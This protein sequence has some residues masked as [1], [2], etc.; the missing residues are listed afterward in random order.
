M[1]DHNLPDVGVATAQTT[2]AAAEPS[3]VPAARVNSGCF[4]RGKD[5]RRRSQKPRLASSTNARA[6]AHSR[7]TGQLCKAAVDGSIRGQGAFV[8][9]SFSQ[10]GN[11]NFFSTSEDA[12]IS[13]DDWLDPEL[14]RWL[15]SRQTGQ[16]F[17]CSCATRGGFTASG[18]I[19]GRSDDET[20]GQRQHKRRRGGYISSAVE[21]TNAQPAPEAGVG[22]VPST[23]VSS[24]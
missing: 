7:G 18:G 13:T 24:I 10:A 15:Q 4:A 8:I 22:P 1:S 21:S 2:S 6:V 17:S 14:Q 20:D 19:L 23:A 16:P 3:A 11:V 12:E 9:I 5:P